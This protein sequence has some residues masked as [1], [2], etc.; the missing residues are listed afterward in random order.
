MSKRAQDHNID[1]EVMIK[2]GDIIERGR[3]KALL[4]PRMSVEKRAAIFA[5]FAA[6]KGH[7]SAIEETGRRAEERIRKQDEREKWEDS[8]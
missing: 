5:P 4:K 8:I 6:L 1:N 2:Y 3:P 7:D